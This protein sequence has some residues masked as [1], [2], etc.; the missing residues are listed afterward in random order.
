M[1]WYDVILRIKDRLPKFTKR[2]L[3]GLYDR[4]AI[5]KKILKDLMEYYDMSKEEVMCMLK[6]GRRLN[7]ELWNI[8]SP[9]TEKEILKF[10]EHTPFYVFDL[11]YWHTRI[12]Q[13]MFRK[14]VIKIAKGDILDYG[15]GV[16]DLC[17][18]LAKK[19]HR[20]TYADIYGKTFEFAKWLFERRGVKIRMIDL[21]RQD[22]EKDEKYNT[23]IYIDV[24]KHVLDQKSLLKKLVKHLRPGG[25]LIITHLKS[26][27]IPEDYPMHFKIEFDAED[28]LFSLGLVKKKE[29]LWIKK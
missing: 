3:S 19:G 23:I 21:S 12:S 9:K 15:A 17:L 14:E 22:I 27:E 24:I 10:Y 18:E 13:K 25:F 16:G 20:V 6:L 7:M 28:Y 8:L 2:W 1:Y 4:W 26:D 5:D 11:I 29:W